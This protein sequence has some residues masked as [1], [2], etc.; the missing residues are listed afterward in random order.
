MPRL[1]ADYSF[2]A[3]ACPRC[4]FSPE[5]IAGFDAWAPELA[6]GGGG[7]KAEYFAH[8]ATLEAESFWFRARNSLIV[9]ALRNY[10]PKFSS[11]LEVGCGP[12]SVLS[13]ISKAF[14]SA[15]VVGSEV[16]SEGL[17]FAAQ[18]GTHRRICPNGCSLHP[19]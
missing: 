13:G 16:L 3:A 8:L 2:D 19:V 1:R 14:P 17:A 5:T 10:F 7:F 15:K 6:R 18:Q 12:G 4:G 9:W 11:F